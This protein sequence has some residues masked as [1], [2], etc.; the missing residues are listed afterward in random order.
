MITPIHLLF[1]LL[2]YSLL[3]YS[4]IISFAYL[5]LILLLASELIDLD[6]LTAKPIYHA[7]RN[8]FKTHFFH[9][10]WCIVLFAS[11]ILVFI[12][13][14]MFLGIGLI[15]HLLLDYVYNKMFKIK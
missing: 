5:D 4:K 12:R 2:L 8:S 10:N 9:K 15:S 7:K 14:V 3:V 13:P 6:H 11:I 1:N